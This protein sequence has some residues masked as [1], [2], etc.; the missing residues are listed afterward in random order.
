MQDPLRR[1]KLIKLSRS[2]IDLAD[3]LKIPRNFSLSSDYHKT[4]QFEQ[5]TAFLITTESYSEILRL[6][7]GFLTNMGYGQ[8]A[9]MTSQQNNAV[10][11]LNST[12]NLIDQL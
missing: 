3:G 7:A 11:D 4:C 8:N 10:A 9:L 1:I 12:P 6:T 5:S 2:T